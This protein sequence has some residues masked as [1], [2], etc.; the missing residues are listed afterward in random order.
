[1]HGTNGDTG[2]IRASALITEYDGCYVSRFTSSL[3]AISHHSFGTAVDVN[4][5]MEPNKNNDAN[6]D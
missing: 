4:A 2:L 1:M 5:S 3:K 6:S